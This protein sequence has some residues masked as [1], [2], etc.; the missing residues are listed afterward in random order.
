MNLDQRVANLEKVVTELLKQQLE[1]RSQTKKFKDFVEKLAAILP[2]IQEIK[3]DEY[4]KITVPT[5]TL[6][7][8]SV[9]FIYEKL[10]NPINLLSVQIDLLN[11][12]LSCVAA[13]LGSF[14]S[15]QQA[16]D[17]TAM[18]A[19]RASRVPLSEES[20]KK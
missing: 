17:S 11:E 5:V 3:S 14:V 6:F 10:E 7:K 15:K 16:I 18:N 4:D 9:R 1:E 12:N 2:V 13:L 20:H 19:G 8:P